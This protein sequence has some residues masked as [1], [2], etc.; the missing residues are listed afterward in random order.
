MNDANELARLNPRLRP[1]TGWTDGGISI[2]AP[3]WR[4][5]WSAIC[6]SVHVGGQSPG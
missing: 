1:T 4:R 3:S 5:C 2:Q 6:L